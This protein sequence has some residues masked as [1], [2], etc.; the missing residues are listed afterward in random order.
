M[1]S[2]SHGASPE[3][4]R[5]EGVDQNSASVEDVGA[6]HDHH[7]LDRLHDLAFAI[8]HVIEHEESAEVIEFR[9]RFDDWDRALDH[10]LEDRH[11]RKPA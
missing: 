3:S 5:A 4:P 8:E 1:P 6:H 9:E 11:G 10:Y 2:P 7:I